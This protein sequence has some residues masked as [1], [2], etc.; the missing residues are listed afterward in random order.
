M[1]SPVILKKPKLAPVSE[2]EYE[3]ILE[4]MPLASDYSLHGDENAEVALRWMRQMQD[5]FKDG[6]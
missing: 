3:A 6:K 5:K 4:L 1:D 2:A